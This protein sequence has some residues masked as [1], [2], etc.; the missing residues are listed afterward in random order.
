MSHRAPPSRRTLIVIGA[1][2]AALGLYFA[3]A[4]L[5]IVPPPGK[6]NAPGWVVML[7]GAVFLFGGIAVVLGAWA[8]ADSKSGELPASVPQWLRA[9]QSLLG[10]VIV[11]SFALIG[12]WIAVGPGE[13]RFTGAI[14]IGD[15]G[16]RIVFGI[17]AA[18]VW[19]FAVALARRAL[20]QL[21]G[22]RT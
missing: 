13:R 1:I 9:T 2:T 19:L 14:P 18:M 6:A 3:L 15:T 12:T 8:G 17:G 7:A 20:R 11:L 21:R 10:L 5:G 16:G 22:Q 4:G